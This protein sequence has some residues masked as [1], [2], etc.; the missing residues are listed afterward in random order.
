MSFRD[1]DQRAD[2]VHCL[3]GSPDS[4]PTLLRL[5]LPPLCLCLLCFLA[6]LSQFA[7]AGKPVT[8][9]AA[10]NQSFERCCCRLSCDPR[11]TTAA[12]TSE[13]LLMVG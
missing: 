3:P 2:G 9:Q 6:G 4:A 10:T 7:L 1:A 11:R 12:H 8:E 13:A 5:A